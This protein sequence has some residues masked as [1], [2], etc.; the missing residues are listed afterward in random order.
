MV[1]RKNGVLAVWTAVFIG[2]FTVSLSVSTI[3]VSASELQSGLQMESVDEKPLPIK[4]TVDGSETIDNDT[5]VVIEDEETPQ[6]AEVLGA[7]GSAMSAWL[8]L[9]ATLLGGGAAGYAA[10]VNKRHTD[11][12]RD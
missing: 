2:C 1:M 3:Q 7:G 12:R 9:T 4:G 6:A 11:R 5:V 10:N 8:A